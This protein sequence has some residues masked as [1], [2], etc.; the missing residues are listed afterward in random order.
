M[1]SRQH[2]SLPQN[3]T[4]YLSGLCDV[5]AAAQVGK[6]HLFIRIR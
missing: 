4:V 6:L 3:V 5:P 1:N 2:I